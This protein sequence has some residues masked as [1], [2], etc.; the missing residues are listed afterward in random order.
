VDDTRTVHRPYAWRDAAEYVQFSLESYRRERWQHQP[1]HVEVWS[2]KSTV[3][4][5]LDPVLRKYGI[6]VNYIHGYTSWTNSHDAAREFRRLQKPCVI[7]YVGDH[8]PSGR[9]M[10]DMDIPDNRFAWEGVT[11]TL[12]RLAILEPEARAGQLPSFPAS[13]KRTDSRY[14][15]F[16]DHHGDTCWELD[17]LSPTVLR[18]TVQLAIEEYIDWDAWQRSEEVEVAEKKSMTDFLATWNSATG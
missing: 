18:E 10:S 5:T 12:R 1:T 17:A 15:W 16:L 2:E 4:G 3:R 8:D 13:D 14:Q 7:L 9:H 6:A 11:M